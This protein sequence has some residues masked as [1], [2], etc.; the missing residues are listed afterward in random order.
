MSPTI[1]DRLP[2]ATERGRYGALLATLTAWGRLFRDQPALDFG[3][4]WGTSAV[5]LHAAGAARVVG[6]E[7]DLERVAKGCA[8]IYELG[9]TD[10]IVLHHARD[11]ARLPWEDQA[12]PFILANG[13]LEHVP[14]L[15]RPAILREVW[16][17]LAP[18]GHLMIAETPNAYYPKD[19][20]TTHLW[21]N[22]WL[23]EQLAHDRAV[24]A[25]AFRADRD[26]WA[27]SGWRGAGYYELVRPLAGARLIPEPLTRTR[28]RILAA[29]GL[30]PMLIDP[31]PTW[32]FRKTV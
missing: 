23:P 31:W 19:E 24:R 11:T 4:S 22:H 28:Q 20:H 30:P 21:L 10:S 18:G 1:L 8:L 6:I 32:V 26:D 17:V 5:A 3:C 13:V 14:R 29:V 15:I 12:F 7:P 9:L 27:T 2:S 16:R 25:G